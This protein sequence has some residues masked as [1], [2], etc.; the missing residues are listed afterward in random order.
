VIGSSRYY[1]YDAEAGNIA[2][3]YTFLARKCWASGYNKN[4][5]QLMIDYAFTFAHSVSFHVGKHN[6]R[7]QRAVQK[8]GATLYKETSD[9][10]EYRLTKEQW[11]LNT[12]YHTL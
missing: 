5:K 2:I 7:S 4:M 1:D 9:S 12:A 3:G 10:N 6:Y 8:T 11:N